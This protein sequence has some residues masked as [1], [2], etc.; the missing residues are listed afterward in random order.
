MVVASMR[1][2]L[3]VDGSTSLKDKRRVLQSLLSR[4]RQRFGLAV[5][6][7][8]DHELWNSAEIGFVAVGQDHLTLRSVL[9]RALEFAESS[10]DGAVVGVERFEERY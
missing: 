7:V 3:R 4:L 8:G 5:S 1:L 2:T 10:L 9:D 6:E